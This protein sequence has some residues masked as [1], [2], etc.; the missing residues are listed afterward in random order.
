MNMEEKPM[1]RNRIKK[2][3]VTLMEMMIVILII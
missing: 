1:K 3:R 2:R